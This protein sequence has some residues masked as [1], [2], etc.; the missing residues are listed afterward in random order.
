MTSKEIDN[1]ILAGK[2]LT[3]YFFPK[4]LIFEVGGKRITQKQF[5]SAKDRF[6][7]RLT[8]KAYF[9][10]ITKHYYTLIDNGK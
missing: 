9:S 4:H 8:Y 3:I 10:G 1:L 6:S 7:N 5:N 2:S